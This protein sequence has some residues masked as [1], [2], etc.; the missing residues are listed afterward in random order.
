MAGSVS[1]KTAE[2]VTGEVARYWAPSL[3]LADKA[4]GAVSDALKRTKDGAQQAKLRRDLDKILE[5]RTVLKLEQ[6]LVRRV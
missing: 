6:D 4:L 3:E 2:Y 5:R 1:A